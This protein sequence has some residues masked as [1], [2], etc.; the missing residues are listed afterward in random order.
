MK[1]RYIPQR[2]SLPATNFTR[3]HARRLFFPE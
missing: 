3:A 2:L 1:G